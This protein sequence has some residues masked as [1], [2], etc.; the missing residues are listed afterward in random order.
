MK[1]LLLFA[2]VAASFCA[3]TVAE[4]QNASTTSRN[5][6]TAT[7]SGTTATPTTAT[8]TR[9]D[10][11]SISRQKTVSQTTL[12]APTS[13]IDGVI[14]RAARSGDPV[15]MVNPAA[16]AA[17]GTGRDVTRHEVDDPYQRPQGIKLV[18]VEF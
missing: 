8:I 13:G 11:R 6:A 4:A 3:A 18:T 2:A 16:P 9:R 5:N 15:Q 12:A 1:T 17:Y 10:K 7:A 14:A